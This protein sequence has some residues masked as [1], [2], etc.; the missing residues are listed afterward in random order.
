MD[1]FL[2]EKEQIQYIREW[3][4]ENRSYIFIVILVVVGGITGNN[5]LFPVIP[6]TTTNITIKIYDLFSCHH[7]RIY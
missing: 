2:S 1:E 5:A 4:Q 7:S 3:W 6:P